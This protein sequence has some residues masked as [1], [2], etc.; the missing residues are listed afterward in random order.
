MTEALEVGGFGGR[1]LWCRKAG[2]AHSC[3][4]FLPGL[5]ALQVEEPTT[6]APYPNTRQ[7][8]CTLVP[9]HRVARCGSRHLG[10]AGASHLRH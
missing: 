5:S 1:A 9:G 7:Q 8:V 4:R 2:T 6:W 3:Q 10:A